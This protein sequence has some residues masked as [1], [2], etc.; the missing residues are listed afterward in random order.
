[1]FR[2]SAASSYVLPGLR[3]S[4]LLRGGVPLVSVT[5]RLPIRLIGGGVSVYEP[6]DGVPG[7]LGLVAEHGVPSGGQAYEFA[8]RQPAG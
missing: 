7:G 6:D 8:A 3:P 5:R 2:P 1:M 4:A